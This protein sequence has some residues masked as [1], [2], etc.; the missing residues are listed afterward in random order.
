MSA[1][2]GVIAGVESII[3][4]FIPDP[5]DA[6]EAQLALLKLH[7]AI[8]MAEA[9]SQDG[10]TSRARP[11]FMYVMY[12]MI[13]SCIPMGILFA[14]DPI[15]ADAVAKGMQMWLAAIPKILWETF[16]VCFSVYTV[17]RTHEKQP[18]IGTKQ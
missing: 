3:N 11:T 14:L 10:W 1:I 9:S 7:M 15:S 8:P 6:A 13:L 4:R 18:F 17:S 16:G 12:I 2:L 5:K